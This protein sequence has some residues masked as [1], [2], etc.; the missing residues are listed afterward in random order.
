MRI[1]ISQ[2]YEDGGREV[3]KTYRDFVDHR[4]TLALQE[5]HPCE[6]VPGVWVKLLVDNL[7]GKAEV[8][9]E[10]ESSVQVMLDHV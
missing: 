4:Y 7:G 6:L 2:L 9:G 8:R 1:S 10:V 5:I 3:S